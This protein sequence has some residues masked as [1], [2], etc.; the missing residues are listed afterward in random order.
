MFSITTNA[1]QDL[2]VGFIGFI[3][4]LLGA[5]IVFVIG[6]IIA[7]TIGKIIATALTKLKF[8]ELFNKSDWQR[9]FEKAKF[10]VNPSEFLGA[11][12][13]WIL[14]IVFLL[15]SA[16]ILGLNQFSIFLG[17]IVNYLPNVFVAALIFIVA[18]ILADIVE[19]IVVASTEKME[20]GYSNLVGTIVKWSIWIFAI[21]AILYQLGVARPMVQTFFAGFIT[22]FAIA[23]GLA[24]GL[25]GKTVAADILE[26]FRKKF[27][28][29]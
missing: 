6:W 7:S 25:G 26:D 2:W 24:F 14:V 27:K 9:A 28:R 4:S 17:T 5:I 11:I 8:N 23:F 13:K 12:A 29:E 22:M 19:K 3:P 16:D 15:A 21:L 18:V 10:T 1:L 20:V